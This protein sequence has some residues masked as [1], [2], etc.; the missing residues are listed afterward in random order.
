MKNLLDVYLS[1][2]KLNTDKGTCHD[3]I[4]SYYNQEFLNKSDLELNILEIGIH[5]GKSI[6]LWLNYFS[7][8]II[9]GIDHTDIITDN[10]IRN[11]PRVK[12]IFQNAYSIPFIESFDDNFFDYIIDDG[13]HDFLSQFICM[14]NW[15]KKVKSGGKLIIEDIQNQE[16]LDRLLKVAQSNNFAK[17]VKL[18]DLRKNKNRY[19]DVIIE[20]TKL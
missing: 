11:H 16:T 8:S 20:L 7:R 9:Y 12:L 4:I 10:N 18:F 13:P 1:D 3:Y 19:D 6:D 15:I 14:E 5:G 2:E 17:E